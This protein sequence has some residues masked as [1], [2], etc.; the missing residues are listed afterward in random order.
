[1]AG[2]GSA[3]GGTA[4]LHRLCGQPALLNYESGKARGCETSRHLQVISVIF[5]SWGNKVSG[6]LRHYGLTLSFVCTL[7][8]LLFVV[9]PDF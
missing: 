1:M 7:T 9:L 8:A 6:C 3:A 5:Q 2:R 4:D